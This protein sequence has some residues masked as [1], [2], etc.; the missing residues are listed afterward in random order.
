[1]ILA[2]AVEVG[3][4][5]TLR[6]KRCRRVRSPSLS[7]PAALTTIPLAILMVAPAP[8]MIWWQ[9]VGIGVTMGV[10]VVAGQAVP[11][12]QVDPALK[13]LRVEAAVGLEDQ[14]RQEK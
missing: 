11:G 3:L 13:M 5:C 9:T 2:A 10:L 1:M 8:L 4:F 14:E 7:V 12:T 6:A